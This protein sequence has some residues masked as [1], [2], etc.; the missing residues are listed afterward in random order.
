MESSGRKGLDM[1]AVIRVSM[2]LLKTEVHSGNR[3][4]V[5]EGVGCACQDSCNRMRWTSTFY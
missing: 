1:D 2:N 5:Y 3:A 4:A